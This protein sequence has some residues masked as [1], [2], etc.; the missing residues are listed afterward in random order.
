M[1]FNVA[2]WLRN[3]AGRPFSPGAL[4]TLHRCVIIAAVRWCLQTWNESSRCCVE[5]CCDER[6]DEALSLGSQDAPVGGC[7]GRSGVGVLALL[8]VGVLAVVQSLK[9]LAGSVVSVP[10]CVM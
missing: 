3:P 5:W 7:G 2:A 6:S 9:G 4:V 1:E 10:A 8:E